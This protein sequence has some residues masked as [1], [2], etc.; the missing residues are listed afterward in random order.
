MR[1]TTWSVV[2]T[3]FVVVAGLVALPQTPAAAAGPITG[4][5]TIAATS[6]T[7]LLP[8]KWA[9]AECPQGKVV[10]GGGAAI[11]GAEDGVFFRSMVPG[12]HPVTGRHRYLVTARDADSVS[13]PWRVLAFATCADPIASLH[14]RTITG[15]PHSDAVGYGR[16]F[17]G[18]SEA[19]IGMGGAV[20]GSPYRTFLQ[21][22]SPLAW[23][24]GIT[25]VA[26]QVWAVEHPGGYD[27]QWSVTVHAL[28]VPNTVTTAIVAD[29]VAPPGPAEPA[30]ADLESDMP[31]AATS[32][33]MGWRGGTPSTL[34]AFTH[35][36]PWGGNPAI[37]ARIATANTSGWSLSGYIV[38]ADH[39]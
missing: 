28:C 37:R 5:E 10:I 15:P 26:A 32:A 21:E 9:S 36:T 31:L 4:V 16:S 23:N 22:L 38:C 25:P 30:C 13:E 24:T 19:L 33:G 6:Q 39:G 35:V 12:P 7:D 18:P 27:G 29:H 17:C 11:D 34:P 3:V 20:N 1:R 8:L 14:L 2:W